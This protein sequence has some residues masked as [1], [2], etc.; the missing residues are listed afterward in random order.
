M[1]RRNL[2][3]GSGGLAWLG[4][5]GGCRASQHGA[6]GP[7]DP[8]PSK[9]PSAAAQDID[10]L[11]AG[12]T[13][14]RAQHQP[15]QASERRQRRARAAALLQAHGLD[16]FLCEGGATMSYLTGVGW[17]HSERAFLFG[18]CAD[19]T[20][21]WLVPAFEASKAERVIAGMDAELGRALQT[22]QEHE[23]AFQ[24]LAA[25]L[26]ARGIARVGLDPKLRLFV[27]DGL[28]RAAPQIAVHCASAFVR[29]LRSIKEPRELELLRRANELTQ[30][31]L[32]AVAPQVRAGQTAGEIADLVSRAQRRLGLEQVWVLSLIGPEAALPHGEDR[33]RRLERDQFVLVDTGGSFH[34]YQSDQT[35]TWIGVGSA[36]NLEQRVWNTVRDAQRRAF[37][38]IRPGVR[39]AEIDRVAREVIER[40]GFGSGYAALTHRLGHGIGLEGHED[41][42]FDGGS[43]V[44]LAPGMTL[45]DE[46]GIYMPGQLGVRIEDIVAVTAQG[47]DHFGVWQ[48]SPL[49]PA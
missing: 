49:S 44:L 38:A 2:L 16:A 23:Y 18:L 28:Q 36:G 48:A 45:S 8:R 7:S 41:P 5:V 10:A 3:S 27:A 17:G 11:F 42:Y 32:V 40:A 39:A 15:I 37:E 25:A 46:P 22:W 12:L 33:A 34:G 24:P 35:R 20:A 26:G 21:F 31:A 14:Q 30:Q 13:D 43:D 6:G 47:A 1:T 19:A 4:L 29:E 9:D